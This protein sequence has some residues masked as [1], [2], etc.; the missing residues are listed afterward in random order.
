[1]SIKVAQND[2]TR[3]MKV[4]TPLQKLPNNVGNLGKIIVS[5]GFKKLPNVQ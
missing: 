5:T 4:L 1:M 3:K 2:F